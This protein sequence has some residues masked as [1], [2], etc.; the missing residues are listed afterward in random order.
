MATSP[1]HRFGQIIGEVLERAITPLL[2][3]FARQ[4]GLYL[5]QPGPR[6]A[7]PGSKVTWS[8]RLGNRH[9]L[10]FVLERGGTADR[11]GRPV[12]FIE[13][14]WRR[15]TKH[16]RNKAQE[17]QGAILPLA[18]HY[19][20]AAPFIGVVLAGVFTDGALRQL[21]SLGFAVVYFSHDAIL[22]S[23]ATVGFDA[24]FGEQTTDRELARKVR[25]WG[26]FS[27]ETRAAVATA[28][29]RDNRATLAEFMQGLGAAARRRIAGVSVLALHGHE[30]SVAS[31]REA[32][33][34]LDGYPAVAAEL[35]VATFVIVVRFSNGSK[36]E[37][38]FPEKAEAMRFLQGYL[39][40]T[41]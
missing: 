15:Y 25:A 14:A 13:T 35:P 2:A 11:I 21:R 3:D 29:V 23:F 6:P 22:K 20:E 24:A 19:R 18:E 9:D 33:A 7:R 31:V 1:S 30:I 4:H 34:L 5:D 8:D 10:D 16:S 37:G 39:D 32:L 41:R 26:K 27:D 12:A 38:E 36:V 17:I 40:E 28:L